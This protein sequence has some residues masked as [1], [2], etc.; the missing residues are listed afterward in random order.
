MPNASIHQTRRTLVYTR[1]QSNE[2]FRRACLDIDTYREFDLQTIPAEEESDLPDFVE[3]YASEAGIDLDHGTVVVWEK[4][5]RLTY[6]TPA[7]L[8]EHLLS[9][10]SVLYRYLE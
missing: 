2:R 6:R 7:K 3:R 10:F 5:D 8:K 4:P 1:T 9:D